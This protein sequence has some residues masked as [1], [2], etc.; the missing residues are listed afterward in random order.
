MH[1]CICITYRVEL[2]MSRLAVLCSK[3]FD[4]KLILYIWTFRNV[5]HKKRVDDFHNHLLHSD[6][7]LVPFNIFLLVCVCVWGGGGVNK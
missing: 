5:M 7:F 4:I 2:W 3:Y 6:L 1:S